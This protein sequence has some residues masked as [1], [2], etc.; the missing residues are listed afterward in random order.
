MPWDRRPYAARMNTRTAVERLSWSADPYTKDDV[1]TYASIDHTVIARVQPCPAG[2]SVRLY[3]LPS[4]RGGHFI[5]DSHAAG[6]R[7]V[8]QWVSGLDI[9]EW[10]ALPP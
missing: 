1:L 6:M 8:V 5:C 3:C 10:P 4:E 7:A 2:W 9:E